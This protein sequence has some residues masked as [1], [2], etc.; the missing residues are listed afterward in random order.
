[1][2]IVYDEDQLNYYM[3][4]AVDASTIADAPILVDK[5]LDNATECDVDCLADY[6]APDRA[7]RDRR[8]RPI[9]IGVMEHIEEAGIHSGDSAC[10]LPPYSLS[11]EIVERL[12]EQTQAL[13]KAL[14]VR[15]LMNVQYAIKDDEIYVIEVNPR[16]QPHRAVRRQGDRRAVGE[17]RGQ[18]DGR[19]DARRARRRP[20]SPTAEAHQREGS[21]LPVQQVPRRRRH[22]RPGDAQHRRGDG[23]RRDLRAGVRQEPARGRHD[24]ADEGQRLRQRPRRRQGR[25]SSRSPSSW[26]TA[27]FK[28]VATGGTYD[29]AGQGTASRPTRINKLAEGRPNIE[30]L[31]RT[32][33][34]S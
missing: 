18:G 31:S 15:G 16:A 14:R 3:A 8:R 25:R 23:H 34:S 4:N 1:M 30:R 17:D 21:R 33:R 10:A 13:A 5:F 28:L 9:V 24:A 7:S 22:P 26:P 20:S 12:K 29:D 6:D 27:G 11:T 19:Q 32:A 2:E